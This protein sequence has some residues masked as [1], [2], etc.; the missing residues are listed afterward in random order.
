MQQKTG[1]CVVCKKTRRLNSK[2]RCSECQYEVTHGR[3]RG[4]VYLER[5]IERERNRVIGYKSLQKNPLKT[6]KKRS[7]V[8]VDGKLKDVRILKR[9]E[10]INKDEKTYEEVFNS[11]SHFCE[12]CGRSLSSE[13]RDENGM[14]IARWQY[15]H[16]L[17]KAAYPEFRNDFRNY[18]RL[19]LECHGKWEFGDRATM[20][21]FEINKKTIQKLLNEKNEKDE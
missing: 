12:E 2:N 1:E 16:I 15:S 18:N 10:Q 4:E 19:C 20:K 6:S 3:S 14:V 5:K 13:F 11:K 17:T 7:K 9:T 21:I 8:I